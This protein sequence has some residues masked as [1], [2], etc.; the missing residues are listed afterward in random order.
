MFQCFTQ[1]S[2][3][4][5]HPTCAATQ[6]MHT[7][8]WNFQAPLHWRVCFP[9]HHNWVQQQMLKLLKG[10][11]IV[12]GDSALSHVTSKLLLR[13][14]WQRHWILAAGQA[15]SGMSLGGRIVIEGCDCGKLSWWSH[16]PQRTRLISH[17]VDIT[18]LLSNRCAREWLGTNQWILVCKNSNW[19]HKFW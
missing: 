1:C 16:S 9:L 3:M 15:D 13:E 17:K 18:V 2:H 8:H 7:Q 6:G 14:S 4:F 11:R 12:T 5:L 10:R 19:N